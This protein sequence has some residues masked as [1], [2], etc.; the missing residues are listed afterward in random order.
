GS[1]RGTRL[2]RPMHSPRLHATQDETLMP[3][4]HRPQQAGPPQTIEPEAPSIELVHEH[5]VRHYFDVYAP[6]LTSGD[7]E[8]I[9]AMR[10]RPAL[11]RNDRGARAVREAGG[12]QK[13]FAGGKGMYAARG[14]V[15]TRPD[16][17]QIEWLTERIVIADVRWPLFDDGHTE[18]G[19]ESS[20]YTLM[21]D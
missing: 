9:A 7:R 8:A 19:S 21:R 5:E 4:L 17:Q 6:P 10:A 13:L 1:A 11:R 2:E 20:T 18:R 15:D 3:Q 16:I 12:I 14:I